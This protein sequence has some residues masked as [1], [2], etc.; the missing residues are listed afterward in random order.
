MS[1]TSL[2]SKPGDYGVTTNN[3]TPYIHVFWNVKDSPVVDMPASTRDVG[4][5][6]TLMD[7]WHRP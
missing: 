5:T 4:L 7:A 6:G 1:P 2:K 3:T